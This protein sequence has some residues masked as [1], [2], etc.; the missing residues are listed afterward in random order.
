MRVAILARVSRDS[1]GIGRSVEEQVRDGRDWAA[2]ENW[3]VVDVITETGS[4]SRFSTR[5]SRDQWDTAI[6]LVE[7]GTIDALITWENSRATR[8]LDGYAQLRN[9]CAR[10]GVR[11]G[12][13]GKL[14]DLSAREDRFRTGLD[15]LLAEDEA[16]RT[17]ERVRRA[18]AANAV[19]G[20]PHGKNLYGYTRVHDATTRVL[21]SIVPDPASAPIVQEAARR[22]LH[23]DTLYAVAADFNDRGIPPR[24]PKR[25]AH[26]EAE[27]WTPVAVKQMLNQPA[28]AGMRQHQGQII[29]AAMWEPLIPLDEWTELQAVLNDPA[30][31]RVTPWSVTH[32]LT[33]I[34]ECGHGDCLGRL[35]ASRNSSVTSEN[36]VRTRRHYRNY[37]C[38]LST[39][40]SVAMK[41]A[42]VII[43]E[44]AIERLS[45]P[46]FLEAASSHD[47]ADDGTRREILA[48]IDGHRRWLA[49]V[50]VLAEQERDL[51]LLRDQKR[52]V[53]PK[54]EAA[55]RRLA[56]LMKLDSRAAD[57]A[58]EVDIRNA[59]EQLDVDARREIIGSL[60]QIVVHP[61]TRRGARGL[62][63]AMDRIE[64]RW[65]Q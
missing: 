15:A 43:T 25:T 3:N 46:D 1:S 10:N 54:I 2:R 52:I 9:A 65:R 14:F 19:A 61:A 31:R 23:G 63:Q 37:R 47:A 59:W 58:R 11:W 22:L 41:Y 17:S 5:T 64:I 56:A 4:A 48:E 36:G 62:R 55:N 6:R 26:R 16:E 12:Y 45:R 35:V 39:H 20:K 30:R 21:V 50:A 28:Y 38:R 7:S 24:R 60:M 44:Q 18:I 53:E 42:D 8:K 57:L 13:G 40:T 34:A 33:G 29:G 32:L 51:R 27:G 49:E